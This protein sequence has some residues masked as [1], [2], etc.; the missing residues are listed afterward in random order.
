MGVKQQIA[1][2]IEPMTPVLTMVELSIGLRD[3]IVTVSLVAEG[4]FVGCLDRAK[5][6]AAVA[7]SASRNRP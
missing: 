3:I 6:A 5:T 1:V 4:S 2:V 7:F